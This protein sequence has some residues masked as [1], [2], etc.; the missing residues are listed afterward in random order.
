MSGGPT[1]GDQAESP[2]Q[3]HKQRE[4]NRTFKGTAAMAFEHTVQEVI[5]SREIEE[6]QGRTRKRQSAAYLEVEF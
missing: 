1:R 3:M 4:T 6:S 5:V 2:N